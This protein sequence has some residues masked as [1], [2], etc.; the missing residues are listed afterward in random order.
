MRDQLQSYGEYWDGSLERWQADEIIARAVAGAPSVAGPRSQRPFA[1]RPLAAGVAAALATLLAVGGGALMLRLLDDEALDAGDERQMLPVAPTVQEPPAPTATPGVTGPVVV[2][3]LPTVPDGTSVPPTTVP[4]TISPPFV[5]VVSVDPAATDYDWGRPALAFDLE[6]Q[7]QVVYL[8]KQGTVGLAACGDATCS[9]VVLTDVLSA[10]RIGQSV[11]LPRPGSGPAIWY[12]GQ[13]DGPDGEG[14]STQLVLCEDDECGDAKLIPFSQSGSAR[15][16]IATDPSGQLVLAYRGDSPAVWVMHCVEPTCSEDVATTMVWDEGPDGWVGTHPS[17]A[18]RGGLPV[19]A[20]RVGDND[21]MI[22][23]CADAA[24]ESGL[25]QLVRVPIPN[26]FTDP[27][28]T[29]GPNGE[30]IALVFSGPDMGAET[31]FELA[32]VVACIDEECSDVTI[33]EIARVEGMY[34][35]WSIAMGPDG[36]LRIAWVAEH[37]LVL[38]TCLDRFCTESSVVETGHPADDV[39]I[40]FG[41]DGRLVAAT[42]SRVHDRGLELV[43]CGDGSC[44]LGG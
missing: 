29:I 42:T 39:S 15:P 26:T 19:V 1:G 30:P 31:F 18:L 24:C 14:F 44:E 12:A 35:E 21:V 2:P 25:T 16:S 40:A 7:P 13:G 32:S 20:F 5:G 8:S 17:V 37:H 9:S 3:T 36:M 34:P 28:V 41:A 4:T 10:D 23:E 43:F 33:A 27:L 38:A 22:G 6:G 11:G